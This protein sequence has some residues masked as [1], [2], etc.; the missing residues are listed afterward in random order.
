MDILRG[1]IGIV[2][3]AG[4][5]LTAPGGCAASAKDGVGNFVTDRDTKVQSILYARLGQLLPG[6]SF[7]GEE[8]AEHRCGPASGDCFIVDPIDGTLNFMNGYRHSCVSVGLVRGG[9]AVLGVVFDPFLGDLFCA[10]AGS[11][12]FC[13]DT[14]LF[15]SQ[16]PLGESVVLFGASSYEREYTEVTFRTLRGVFDRSLDLR[17]SGSAALDIC[18]VAA[19][20]CGAFFEYRLSPWDYCAGSVILREA[21]GRISRADGSPLS[22]SEGGSVIAAGPNSYGELLSVTE[23]C[24]SGR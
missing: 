10:E 13:G 21:G 8:D 4:G 2:R 3:E 7:L 20:R 23:T 11:G 24:A 19:A 22:W 12:A 5:L 9:E 18:Y 1:M 15:A 14:R 6:A 16:K 17:S